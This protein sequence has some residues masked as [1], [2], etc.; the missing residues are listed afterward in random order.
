M[1]TLVTH[2]HISAATIIQVLQ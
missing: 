1:L 2:I